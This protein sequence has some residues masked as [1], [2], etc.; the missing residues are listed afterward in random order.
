MK[1]EQFLNYQ[2]S[3]VF[4]NRLD[5]TTDINYYKLNPYVF[6]CLL[7]PL[8][9]LSILINNYR[10]NL[11]SNDIK[12]NSNLVESILICSL[13]NEIIISKL[14]GRLYNSLFSN[15]TSYISHFPIQLDA[16]CNLYLHLSLLTGEGI[17]YLLIIFI[18]LIGEILYFYNF[19]IIEYFYGYRPIS[20]E[21][22]NKLSFLMCYLSINFYF[23]YIPLYLFL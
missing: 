5:Q 16:T 23:N 6:D 19:V 17:P 7:K 20:P 12:I 15:D 18:T 3:I 11:N 1:I 9:E 14:Y 2:G 10:K 13:S 4:R 8:N 22:Y 21:F